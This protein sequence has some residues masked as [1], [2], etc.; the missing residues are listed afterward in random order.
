LLSLI[1][2]SVSNR[3]IPAS[4]NA[5][6][7]HSLIIIE[8]YFR[9]SGK[10]VR[11]K[12]LFT[13]SI[14]ALPILCFSQNSCNYNNPK[15]FTEYYTGISSEYGGLF[16]NGINVSK[17]QF[18][19]EGNSYLWSF[20]NTYN[21]AVYAG[22]L[23]L[24]YAI[25]NSTEIQAGALIQNPH[26][27]NTDTL[28]NQQ[29]QLG[30][31][32]KLFVLEGHR[33]KWYLAASAKYIV[34]RSWTNDHSIRNGILLSVNNSLKLNGILQIDLSAGT[35]YFPSQN[36]F[37]PLMSSKVL[38]KNDASKTGIFIGFCGDHYTESFLNIGIH[39]SDNFNYILQTAV[40][41]LDKAITPN[42][43]YTFLFRN[44]R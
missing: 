38:M 43:S 37:L 27:L 6:D 42:I 22:F 4:G 17:K 23:Q 41:F 9:L 24:R 25:I 10:P 30:I 19:I 36:L 28:Y 20:L 31:K 8:L 21:K 1:T 13:V 7:I 44:L 32:Q 34:Q 18:Q 2:K 11:V 3:T 16:L 33:T 15:K 29:L 40:G 14:Y 35:Q 12:I 5:C 39:Y 26:E